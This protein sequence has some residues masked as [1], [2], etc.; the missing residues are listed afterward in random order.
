MAPKVFRSE[1]SIDIDCGAIAIVNNCQQREEKIVCE[2]A[3]KAGERP[4][5]AKL[6]KPAGGWDEDFVVNN[7]RV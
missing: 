4:P 6:V 2:R 3:H 7:F 1:I 5:T